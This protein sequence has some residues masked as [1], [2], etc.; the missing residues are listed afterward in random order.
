MESATDVLVDR[1]DEVI[2][3]VI[4][5]VIWNR[6]CASR[7]SDFEI[8][9]P[10]TPWIVPHSVQLLILNQQRAL[11]GELMIINEQSLIHL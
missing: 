7:S 8:T 4:V 10:I 5:L 2:Q 1:V 6:P 11:G 3:E 9:S